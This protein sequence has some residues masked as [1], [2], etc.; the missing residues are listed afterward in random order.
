MGRRE[1]A[2]KRLLVVALLTRSPSIS[3]PPSNDSVTQTRT[4]K[5]HKAARLLLVNMIRFLHVWGC[6]A[7]RAAT[8]T[9]AFQQLIATLASH[10]THS[11]DCVCALSGSVAS[12]TNGDADP[13]RACDRSNRL[14]GRW[15]RCPMQSLLHTVCHANLAVTFPLLP[16]EFS[17]QSY[18]LIRCNGEMKFG[19]Q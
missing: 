16:V 9:A 8:P 19:R 14:A 6:E 5:V 1:L 2:A 12:W 17:H 7:K 4:S 3:L 11:S 15:S 13:P 18:C 10:F